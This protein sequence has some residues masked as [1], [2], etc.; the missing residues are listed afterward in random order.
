MPS[1]LPSLT[2]TR[3]RLAIVAGSQ[4]ASAPTSL[5][6]G[7]LSDDVIHRFILGWD[8]TRITIPVKDRDGHVVFFR[9]ASDPKDGA[10]P[11]MLS[12]PWS[13]V[14]LYGQEVFRHEPERIIICEGEL[15]RLVLETHGFHGIT[16]TGGAGAFQEEW[17][18]FLVG[19]PEVYICFDL[20]EAGK[21]GALRVARFIPH[22][23]IVL[24]PGK[25]GDKGDLTDYFVQQNTPRPNSRRCCRLLHVSSSRRL[26][27]PSYPGPIIPMGS[28]MGWRLGLRRGKGDARGAKRRWRLR[29]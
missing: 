16:S 5:R 24:L 2:T 10:G 6:P 15:D 28:L 25:V 21:Q 14:T 19:I 11:K 13:R 27:D 20:D 9:R 12:T 22:A 29:V 23:R 17:A 7:E 26:R 1:P 3:L 4:H 8:G 18:R